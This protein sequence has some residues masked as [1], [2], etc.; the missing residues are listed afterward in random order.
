VYELLSQTARLC[1]E[2]GICPPHRDKASPNST[3]LAMVDDAVANLAEVSSME[4]PSRDADYSSGFNVGD[5]F[6]SNQQFMWLLHENV[7]Y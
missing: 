7:P 1:V 6:Q 4:I 2:S 3:D 5:W